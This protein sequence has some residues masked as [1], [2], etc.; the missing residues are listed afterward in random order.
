[1]KTNLDEMIKTVAVRNGAGLK[2]SD[3]VMQLVTVMDTIIESHTTQ[4]AE[5][6]KALLVGFAEKIEES[7]FSINTDMRENT[8]QSV[9]AVTEYAKDIL[10]KVMT[11]GATE[12]VKAAKGELAAMLLDFHNSVES[13][14]QG[15]KVSVIMVGLS[16]LGT[17]LVGVAQLIMEWKS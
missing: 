5:Q 14:K 8:K 3:A 7:L 12:A 4:L 2:K 10:P 1:M 17:G 11:A 9:D 16:A 15:I 13:F 6:Q